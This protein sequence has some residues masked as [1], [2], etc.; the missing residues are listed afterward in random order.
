MMKEMT[1]MKDSRGRELFS[2]H[3]D[4]RAESA[5][6]RVGPRPERAVTAP[7]D[8]SVSP[9]PREHDSEDTGPR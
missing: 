9:A 4:I 2:V 3:P 1:L 6:Y 8:E 5:V 7:A